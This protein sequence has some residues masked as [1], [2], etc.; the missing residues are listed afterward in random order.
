MRLNFRF[1]VFLAEPETYAPQS[2]R[3]SVGEL[4]G[5]HVALFSGGGSLSVL[6]KLTGWWSDKGGTAEAQRGGSWSADFCKPTSR[7]A[8][9]GGWWD[10]TE[11]SVSMLCWRGGSGTVAA[12]SWMKVGS[13][14]NLKPRERRLLRRFEGRGRLKE[15]WVRHG[16]TPAAVSAAGGWNK[17]ENTLRLTQWTQCAY[18][19]LFSFL[20]AARAALHDSQ[21]RLILL[22][23]F[24][25]F[26]LL[27]RL[28]WASSLGLWCTSSTACTASR[29][30]CL[31]FWDEVCLVS[32]SQKTLSSNHL[33][34]SSNSVGV[35]AGMKT[36][37]R[38]F[39]RNQDKWSQHGFILAAVLKTHLS[40]PC[41]SLPAHGACGS[42][43]ELGPPRS[44][45]QIRR[46][47][48]LP[49]CTQTRS[50]CRSLD[51]WGSSRKSQSE[52]LC[53]R[54]K[55]SGD[56]MLLRS[57]KLCERIF[58]LTGKNSTWINPCEPKAI[59]RQSYSRISSWHLPHYDCLRC[60]FHLWWD[61]RKEDDLKHR[62]SFSK[63][64]K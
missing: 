18:H 20:D 60:L 26:F 41:R 16:F 17:E 47:Q 11:L 36:I 49:P 44:I 3:S 2:I 64:S 37:K 54:P 45:A 10:T 5:T 40:L 42:N 13:E 14:C 4:E 48:D 53:E 46:R 61:K 24:F 31:T 38:T 34:L 7:S 51:W 6:S 23:L 55:K 25:L 32:R 12:A 8:G 9:T 21:L 63:N 58:T 59:I 15:G 39:I 43:S 22:C 52:R 56:T 27:A 62:R 19:S 30:F 50:E 28:L 33:F 35:S 57:S 29:C 1:D